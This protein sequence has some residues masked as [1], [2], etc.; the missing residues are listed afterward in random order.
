LSPDKNIL[1]RLEKTA[2]EF[3]LTDLNLAM[4]MARIASDSLDD[5]E[6]KTRNLENARKAYD[7]VLHL[8]SKSKLSESERGE[9]NGKLGNLRSSLEALGEVF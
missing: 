3:L 7:A 4:T 1:D 8:S 2:F 6:K 9:V 5:P